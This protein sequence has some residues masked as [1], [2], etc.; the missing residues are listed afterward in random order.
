MVREMPRNERPREKMLQEG[1]KAL[2]NAE[3]LAI[4]LR[5]GSKA[6]SVTHLA[7]RVLAQYAQDGL[8]SLG[9]M[10]PRLLAGVKG[11]GAVKAVTVA[12]A[13]ELGKRVFSRPLERTVIRSPQDVI[14]NLAELQYLH[15]EEFRVIFLNTKNDIV[16]KRMISR[17]TINSAV[18]GPREVFHRAVKLMAAAI[19]L[20][21]NHPSGDPN[22]SREDIELTRNMVQARNIMGIAVLDH[23]I[24]GNSSY[25]SFK[26]K[27]LMQV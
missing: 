9:D 7:E 14:N 21:H 12:A 5:T 2:S 4:L 16:A 25:V 18:L 8:H 1:A 17:G 10:P 24:I 27:G 11:I 19:I 20:V 26:D 13:I 23:V 3:L 15:Q 22:P 6:E